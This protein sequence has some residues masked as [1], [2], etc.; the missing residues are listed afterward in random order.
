MRNGLELLQKTLEHLMVLEEARIPRVSISRLWDSL[1]AAAARQGQVR[2]RVLRP[3]SASRSL[4]GAV[5]NLDRPANRR[6]HSPTLK[7]RGDGRLRPRAR[8][9]GRAARGAGR[10][11]PGGRGRGEV[12]ETRRAQGPIDAEASGG[13]RGGDRRGRGQ[14]RQRL[15]SADEDRPRAG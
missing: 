4:G 13:V 8:A 9:D 14:G 15:R 10:Q 11:P 2:S 5:K 3:V 1:V 6:R 12:V 7:S